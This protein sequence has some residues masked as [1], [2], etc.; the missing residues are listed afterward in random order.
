DIYTG[1]EQG[2]FS[3][4]ISF[5]NNAFFTADDG[6]GKKLWKS[7]GTGT[8][9]MVVKDIQPL[10]HP[11]EWVILNNYL[12]FNADDGIS[13]KE[14]W[15]SDG[16]E[17]G[18]EMVKDIN[19]SGDSNPRYLTVV[20]D[21]I[22]FSAHDGTNGNQLWKSDGTNVGTVM[23]K[24]I[25][26]GGVWVY[27]FFQAAGDVLFFVGHDDVHGS[28]LWISDG[29][30]SGTEL[31]EDIRPGTV[32]SVGCGV[33]CFV[34]AIGDILYFNAG[35]GGIHGNELWRSDGTSAGT[36][37]VKDINPLASSYLMYEDDSA[38]MG[39]E[40]FFNPDDGS[41]GHEL[42]RTDGSE[43]GTELIKDIHL[44]G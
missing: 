16:T 36:F 38:V 4:C 22:F 12:Y 18:T 40:L 23:I 1:S 11:F 8:G 31:V 2:V 27:P 14:L 3:N 19:P 44:S 13:G 17:S 35:D 30:E 37:M 10:E 7:D 21:S 15:R 20:S 9:T 6:T 42:W 41:H 5:K 26:G 24:E 39:G 43:T 29:S 32:G 25:T 28:E 34:D 33:G